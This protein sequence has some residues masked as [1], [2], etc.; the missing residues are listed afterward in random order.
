MLFKNPPPPF[1]PA[2]APPSTVSETAFLPNG[3]FRKFIICLPNGT[4]PRI[5]IGSKGL[6]SLSNVPGPFFNIFAVCLKAI[7]PNSLRFLERNLNAAVNG[8]LTK[9]ENA[10]LSANPDSL[11]TVATILPTPI[12]SPKLI[13]PNR[14]K[15]VKN[16]LLNSLSLSIFP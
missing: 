11:V 6:K 14:A 2:F 13:T 4:A 1:T 7:L 15:S 3:L 5:P 12:V 10:S 9:F 8:L 16:F